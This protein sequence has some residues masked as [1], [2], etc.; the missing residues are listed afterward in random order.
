MA[1][2]C[3]L[4][5][6]LIANPPV[7]DERRCIAVGYDSGNGVIT[8]FDF[9]DDGSM[10]VRWTREQNHASHMVFYADTG[11][12][13]TADYRPEAEVKEQLVVLDI[14]T[15]LE[16]TR[17]DTASPIQTVVFPAVG[18]NGDLYWTSTWTLTRVRWR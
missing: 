3:G 11:E 9:D 14:K 6:G 17:I 16:K 10:T 1:E 8:A 12:L 13:V 5:Q 2:I 4:P 18:A 15:G 7:I